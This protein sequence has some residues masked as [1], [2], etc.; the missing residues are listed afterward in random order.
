[1][2]RTDL[3]NPILTPAR[4][5]ICMGICFLRQRIGVILWSENWWGGT[6]WQ[7]G[8]EWMCFHT[9]HVHVFSH[10]IPF[11]ISWSPALPKLLYRKDDLRYRIGSWQ[12]WCHALKCQTLSASQPSSHMTAMSSLELI[13]L[14][15]LLR[16]LCLILDGSSATLAVNNTCSGQ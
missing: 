16:T 15:S 11:C 8:K 9:L 4:T 13:Y 6:E 7:R 14:L 1:M 3:L 10:L 12:N 5:K 2:V